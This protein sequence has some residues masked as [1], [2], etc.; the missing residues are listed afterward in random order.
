MARPALPLPTRKRPIARTRY[1]RKTEIPAKSEFSSTLMAR[2]SAPGASIRRSKCAYGRRLRPRHGGL[3]L[4]LIVEDDPSLRLLC[5]VNLELEHY[6]VLE[7]ETL[8]A[9]DRARRQRADRRRAARP[10]RRRGPRVRA[11]A[12]PPRVA[13]RGRRLPPQRHVPRTIRCRSTACTRSSASR[14]SSRISPARSSACSH[15]SPQGPEQDIRRN[16]RRARVDSRS[17]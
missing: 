11:A 15:A 9:G 6:S 1:A 17:R 16:I 8:G 3:A 10:A 4:V 12:V 2:S 13:P 14:S 7:A 5:R